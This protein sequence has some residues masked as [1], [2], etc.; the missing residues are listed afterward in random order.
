M[1]HLDVILSSVAG[2]SP[3]AVTP[4]AAVTSASVHLLDLGGVCAPVH[5]DCDER[6]DWE[7][8]AV[9]DAERKARLEHRASLV[10]S[11]CWISVRHCEAVGIGRAREAAIDNDAVLICDSAQLVDTGDGCAHEAE[12]EEA[13][14]EAVSAYGW[15]SENGEKGVCDSE[16]GD[17]KEDENVGWRELVRVDVHVHEVGLLN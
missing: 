5:A 1:N 3:S 4:P 11:Q 9:D 6:S 16:Y 2:T 13:D 10:G 7:D 8:D 17:D 14:E 12:I 15:D